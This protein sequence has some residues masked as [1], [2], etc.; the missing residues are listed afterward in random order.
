MRFPKPQRFPTA[1]K[2]IVA[3]QL[4]SWYNEIIPIAGLWTMVSLHA[5]F[6]AVSFKRHVDETRAKTVVE[7]IHGIALNILEKLVTR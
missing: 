3:F 5:S 7:K 1:V 4:T 6:E 2:R